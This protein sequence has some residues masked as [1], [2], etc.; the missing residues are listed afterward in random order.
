MSGQI[1]RRIEVSGSYPAD[2]PNPIRFVRATGGF[3]LDKL[4][5]RGIEYSP[6][7]TFALADGKLRFGHGKKP[8]DG[9]AG[10][11]F[12][13]GRF[14][15][16][17]AEIDL[18]GEH[19]RLNIPGNHPLIR[20]A[21]INPVFAD[22]VIARFVNPAFKDAT[23]AR[24]VLDV[25]VV[26]CRNLAL[27][28][29]MQAT[30][31]AE[32]GRAELQWSLSDLFIGQPEVVALVSKIKPSALSENGFSGSVKDGRIVIEGGQVHSDMT[33]NIDKY[34]LGFNGGIGLAENTLNNFAVNLPKE[35]FVAIDRNFGKQ[36]PAEGYRLALTGTTDNALDN[37]AGSLLPIIADLGVRAGLGSVL[38]RAIGGS[39]GK[40]GD[41]GAGDADST[42]PDDPLGDLLNR[43]LGGNRETDAEKKARRERNRREREERE[44]AK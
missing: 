16:D 34:A 28:K 4:A 14:N 18:T 8:Q 11:P 7:L 19:L 5:G 37:V 21:T 30:H 32:S 33:L 41:K 24:G 13:G 3:A 40:K 42:K 38:D 23:Q 20:G 1:S 31:P 6:D 2:D 12:N 36:V 25:T 15:L 17:G 44:K 35:L 22:T 9:P 39:T 43:A 26:S 29:T 10:D 27:D